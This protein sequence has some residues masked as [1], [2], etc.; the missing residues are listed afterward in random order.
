MLLVLGFVGGRRG[1][2]GNEMKRKWCPQQAKGFN[3]QQATDLR[4]SKTRQ[5]PETTTHHAG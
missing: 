5:R 1:V 4:H 2:C 3:I